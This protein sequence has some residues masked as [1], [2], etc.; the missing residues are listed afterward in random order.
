MAD[1]TLADYAAATEGRENNWGNAFGAGVGGFI[2][3]A[4]GNGGFGFGGGNRGQCA[5]TED[6]AAGFNFAGINNKLN[7]IT[8]GQANANQNLSAAIC[9]S[10]YELGSK[11][12]NCCCNNQLAV[13][14]VKFDMANYASAIQMNDTANTQKVLDRICQFETNITNMQK[15]ATIAAQGQEIAELKTQKYIDAATCGIPKTSPYGY[16]VYAYPTCGGNSCC[17]GAY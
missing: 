6:V 11:I 1:Y 15:D 17:N 8:A 4:L 16:G 5:T 13:Q 14:G 2:G 7:E 12:D 9:S 3:S 10:T